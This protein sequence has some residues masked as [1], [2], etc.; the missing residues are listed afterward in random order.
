MRQS[1]YFVIDCVKLGENDAINQ[2]RVFTDGGVISKS[3]VELYELINSFIANKG[4]SNKQDEIGVVGVD[5]LKNHN[6]NTS[7]NKQISVTVN[8]HCSKR[9]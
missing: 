4:F 7:L 2:T 5:Q 1:P 9:P 8:L 6:I 3:L